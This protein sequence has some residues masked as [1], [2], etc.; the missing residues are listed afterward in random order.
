[1]LGIFLGLAIDRVRSVWACILDGVVVKSL[2]S[3]VTFYR[4]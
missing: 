4:D 3:G 1:M 2:P